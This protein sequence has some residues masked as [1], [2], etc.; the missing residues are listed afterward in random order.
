MCK[1]EE[2][3]FREAWW[4]GGLRNCFTSYILEI[5]VLLVALTRAVCD[6]GGVTGVT[7]VERLSRQ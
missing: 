6:G 1:E 2:V 4:E 7:L 5:K 3:G